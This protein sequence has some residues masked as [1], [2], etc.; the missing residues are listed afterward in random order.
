[1]HASRLFT[2]LAFA[3]ALVG[4]ASP[5]ALFHVRV[6]AE[7]DVGDIE[8]VA[9]ADFDGLEQTGHLVAAKLTEG[10]V[11]GQRFEMYEREKL[12]EILDE[13]AFSH[14]D[15]VDPATANELKLLGIDALIFGIV[16]A[17]GVDDQTGVTKVETVVSTGETETV[18]VTDDDG[19][20]REVEREITKTVYVDR[21]YVLREGTMGV[22]FRM[23]NVNT[24]RIVAI[25]AETAHFSERAWREERSRLPSKD[26]ILDGLAREVTRRFLRQIQPQWVARQVR[27]EE[28]D[29]PQTKVGIRY[30]QSD[31]WDEAAYAFSLAASTRP[32]DPTTHYNLALALYAVGDY[33]AAVTEIQQAIAMDPQDA[34]IRVL[35]R[36]RSDAGI[37]EPA[38]SMTEKS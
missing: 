7:I 20:V 10:I 21:A 12:E 24:G 14:S 9:V 23:A 36:V 4:C 27:F 34:Y 17:Y 18:Q 26:V 19:T 5:R 3:S 29:D 8:R 16:D 2:T 6:P 11:E 31:L 22:T 15:H 32:N 13:R 30:A 38:W 37:A 1:M 28:N 35:A 25:K 33:D